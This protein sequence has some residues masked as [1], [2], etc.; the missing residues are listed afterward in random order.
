MARLALAQLAARLAVRPARVFRL[1][2]C[3]AAVAP[4]AQAPPVVLAHAGAAIRRL[5]QPNE[6]HQMHITRLV[7]GQRAWP[8]QHGQLRALRQILE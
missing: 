6:I 2:R 7:C 4:S 1:C 8:T 5:A 3:M